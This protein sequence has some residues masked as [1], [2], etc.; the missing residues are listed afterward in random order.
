MDC[1]IAIKYIE[2]EFKVTLK[3]AQE[4]VFRGAWEGKT[5][6]QIASN[7]SDF[8]NVKYLANDIGPNLWQSLTES[9]N[10]KISKGNFRAVIEA[11]LSQVREVSPVIVEKDMGQTP[12]QTL[13]DWGEAPNVSMIPIYDE[14]EQQ[15]NELK[16]LVTKHQLVSLIGLNG[17]GKTTVAV[18]LL[19]ELLNNQTFEFIIWRSLSYNPPP[20]LDKI[21]KE[22]L[23]FLEVKEE[24]LLFNGR[25]EIH[26]NQ[27]ISL[28]IEILR[29]KRTL[30]VLDH[31]ECLMQK[32]KIAGQY[33]KEYATYKTLIERLGRERHQSCLLVITQEKPV[34]VIELEERGFSA[35]SYILRGLK[36][37]I[38]K[39]FH[40]HRLLDP[41]K[42]DD[43]IEIFRGHPF[44]LQNIAS[45]IKHLFG[46]SVN[47]YLKESTINRRDINEMLD[48]EISILSDL[49]KRILFLL[50][51]S[52]N[53]GDLSFSDLKQKLI[54]LEKSQKLSGSDL[55]DALESLLQR[56]LISGEKKYRIDPIVKKFISNKYF[57]SH[58]EF[59]QKSVKIDEEIILEAGNPQENIKRLE[60]IFNRS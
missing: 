2:Q 30:L 51:T 24:S 8:P 6:D 17:I 45:K 48:Q 38:K 5:Y 39:N 35:S 20:K 46:G 60:K 44:A 15:I 4:A 34:E 9:L 52:S 32:E 36:E 28:L 41:D 3:P 10:E 27:K 21:L 25:E 57:L 33:Q 50:S 58:P 40:N 14:R 47:N 37:D 29:K 49:E 26:H 59:N 43:L 1:D 42:W 18:K 53:R 31:L 13:I 19:E 55:Q 54:P 12:H 7:S 23:N 11:R 22:I 56:S 16:S